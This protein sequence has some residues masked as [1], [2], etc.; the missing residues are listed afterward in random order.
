MSL[1]NGTVAIVTGSAKGLGKGVV[2]EILKVQEK[3]INQFL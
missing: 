2:E 1:L 3:A